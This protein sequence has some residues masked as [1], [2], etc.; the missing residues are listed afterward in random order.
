MGILGSLTG[1]V[2]IAMTSADIAVSLQRINEMRIPI[3]DLKMVGDLTAE[4]TVSRR[5]YSQIDSMAKRKGDNL[6]V[7]TNLG[8]YWWLKSFL[9]RPLLLCS[10]MPMLLLSLYLP[11]RVLLIEV[12]GN[13]RIPNRLILEAAKE[14]GIRFGASRRAVRSEKMKNELLGV[15]PELQWAGINTYGCRAVITVRERAEE[16]QIPEQNMVSSIVASCDG[17][18][19]ELTVTDGAGL[20][21]IGQAVKKG[22]VL[23]SGYTDC[24]GIITAG[25][26]VG[27]IFAQTYHEMTVLTPSDM[28]TRSQYGGDQTKYS[29]CIGKK[30]INFYKGSGISDA[31]CVK[32]V[33]Q[34]HLTLPGGYI[35]PVSLIKEHWVSCQTQTQQIDASQMMEQLSL[36]SRKLLQQNGVALTIIDARES[37][38]A[39][40]GVI[41]LKGSYNCSEMIGREQGELTGDFHGKTD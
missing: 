34:Y 28:N 4:F 30:R 5:N 40:D 20:C 22:Q 32:M 27:E 33:S 15:L 35:L 9:R 21:G 25:R 11:S 7:L 36:Y 23:I 38:D 29:L 8:I 3:S 24:G 16:N 37:L 19:T 39:N 17:I 12:E 26:A 10:I 6:K 1:S 18:I 14:A 13:S 41:V 31:T 2:R